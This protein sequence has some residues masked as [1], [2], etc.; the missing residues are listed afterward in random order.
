[1]GGLVV[2]HFSWR[3]LFL[4][5]L[6][7]AA[8]A[9]WRLCRLPAGEKHARAPGTDMAGHVLF[10]IGTV[11]LLYWLTSG[12]HR[13]DWASAPSYAIAAASAASLAALY[14]NERRHPVP[15]LPMDLLRQRT[16][17]LSALMVMLWSACLF[18]IIFFLPVYYQLGHRMSAALAGL[19]L[20]PI[21][22]GQVIAAMIAARVLRRTGEPHHIP[23]MG[24]AVC[25]V[26]L[27]LLGLLPANLWTDIP[28]GFIAGLGLGTVMP[29]NQVVVQTAAGRAQLGVVMA[30][31]SLARNTGGAAG[32]ALFGALIFALL[33][34]GASLLQQQAGEREIDGAIRAFHY[35]FLCAAVVA[36]LAA[37]TA[38]HVPRVS[39]WERAGG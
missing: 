36:G 38:W 3:W 39:L 24:M 8:F 17:A 23:V 26:A 27:A 4:A 10:A 14:W 33:P 13:F 20:L 19:L 1:V 9:A 5:N 34:D 25:S 35:G 11:G 2:S 37:L 21:T 15:F 32:A 16:I 31:V 7:F 30:M 18:A 6:P 28:L 12:G 22:A 29:I